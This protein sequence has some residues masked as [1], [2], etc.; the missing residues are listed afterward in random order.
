MLP[1][2]FAA[3]IAMAH[4]SVY[5]LDGAVFHVADAVVGSGFI[6]CVAR[7]RRLTAYGRSARAL[8]TIAADHHTMRPAAYRSTFAAKR[9]AIRYMSARP[10][11]SFGGQG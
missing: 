10:A 1:D 7:A 2:L 8:A 11:C 3:A 4:R 6:A 5:L 9:A